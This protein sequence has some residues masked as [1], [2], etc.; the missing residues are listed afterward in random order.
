[1]VA[2]GQYSQFNMR[3]YVFVLIGLSTAAGNTT[4][5]PSRASPHVVVYAV[6]SAIIVLLGTALLVISMYVN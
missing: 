1:M 2:K 4:S 6:L 5:Q 3:F